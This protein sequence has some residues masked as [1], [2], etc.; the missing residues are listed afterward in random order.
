MRIPHSSEQGSLFTR[1]RRWLDAVPSQTGLERE[2]A[3]LIQVLL[4]GL[5]AILLCSATL[6]LIAVP[7]TESPTREANLSNT[8]T[9][10]IA[11]GLVAI[12][13][14]LLRR[15]RL[16]L[17][18]AILVGLLEAPALLAI[19]IAGPERAW[20]GVLAL[21]LP[22]ALAA[23]VLGRRAL[24]VVTLV[25]IVGVTLSA[26]R[27]AP[28]TSLDSA[29]A[30]SISLMF[31]LLT[32]VLALFLDRFGATFRSTLRE[33]HD[34]ALAT[35]QQALASREND[36]ALLAREMARQREERSILLRRF[37]ALAEGYPGVIAVFNP[38][39]VYELLAGRQI[40]SLGIDPAELR[41]QRLG[42]NV[43]DPELQEMM[44]E[45]AK[46]ALNGE[47]VSYTQPFGDRIYEVRMV[48][49][50]DQHGAVTGGMMITTDI[51]E[52]AR[53]EEKLRESEARLAGIVGSAMDAIITIDHEQRI[54][55]ANRAAEQVFGARAEDLVG[56]S[57]DVLIPER[58]RAA[59]RRH[60]AAFGKSG[61]TTRAMG[62]TPDLW[63]RRANGEEFPIEASISQVTV[64][65]EKLYTAIVRDITERRRQERLLKESEERY[66]L[67]AEHST[68][69]IQLIDLEAEGA[70]RYASPS[71]SQLLGLPQI[72]LFGPGVE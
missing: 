29:N 28:M 25:S 34:A 45:R 23:L 37:H 63:G 2:Q 46:R 21:T 3:R 39:L 11:T 67:I 33:R 48:A 55:L 35:L 8:V 41:G 56:Q 20:A 36:V 7:L 31:A 32:G 6:T 53:T 51:T 66:R 19:W 47:P 62:V 58:L 44:V 52:R 4:L 13:L 22:L 64:G 69:L 54:V 49:L 70:I 5:C 12:P 9:C 16:A 61:V 57:L 24:I 65:G 68:D 42:V 1:L 43:S 26:V 40:A 17:A 10:L 14:V 27:H 18:A 72:A 15:G 30:P 50:R 38:D 59:H 60:V 71:H